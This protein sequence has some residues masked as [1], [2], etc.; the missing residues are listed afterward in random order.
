MFF[1]FPTFLL[2]LIFS[3]L[4]LELD[5]ALQSRKVTNYFAELFGGSDCGGKS[6]RFGENGSKNSNGN[7]TIR[8][9]APVENK[10]VC[11]LEELY[12]G[13]RKN[14]KISRI[15]PD[16]SGIIQVSIAQDVARK[17]FVQSVFCR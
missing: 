4:P 3:L 14:V 13:S 17:A 9:A 8:K 5:S 15:V 16:D 10:L 12:K 7:Q 6:G 2:P 11:S 1:F